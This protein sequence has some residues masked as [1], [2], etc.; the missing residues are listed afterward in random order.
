M[1]RFV[2]K[3]IALL[4]DTICL[5]NFCESAMCIFPT[6]VSCG[7][8]T[9]GY[10]KILAVQGSEKV[11]LAIIWRINHCIKS[12]KIPISQIFAIKAHL[13]LYLFNIFG[14][15]TFPVLKGG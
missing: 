8:Q 6:P 2:S 12:S 15:C 4:S 13:S 7:L 11:L 9:S 1:C 14:L 10:I 3:H 5:S